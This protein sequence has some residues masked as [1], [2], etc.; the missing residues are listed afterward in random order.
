M[1]GGPPRGRLIL[2]ADMPAGG[3]A[4]SSTATLLAVAAVHAA[5][6][7]AALPA[8]AELACLCLGL[9]GATDPLMH[10]DPGRLLWASRAA[11][12]LADLPPLP[13]LEVVGGFQ[14]QASRTDPADL[15]FADISDLVAAWSPAAARGD[16]PALAAL[17]TESARRNTLRRRGPPLDALLDLSRRSGALGIVAAHTGSARGLLF[18]PGTGHPE[19]TLA[20][21]RAMGLHRTRHFRLAGPTV[22]R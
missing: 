18:A 22:P 17:A 7:G 9:E 1:S 2:S 20:A 5:A 21:L 14:G 19:A 6:A 15:D 4:G 13:A 12:A 11:R 10:P 8:P 3:G 16:L